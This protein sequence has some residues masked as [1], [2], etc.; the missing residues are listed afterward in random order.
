MSCVNSAL[1]LA[2]C[3]TRPEEISDMMYQQVGLRSSH[4]SSYMRIARS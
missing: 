2:M 1:R 3:L 4:V